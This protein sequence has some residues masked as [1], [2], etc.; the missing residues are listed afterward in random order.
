MG[1]DMFMFK[2][3][4]ENTVKKIVEIVEALKCENEKFIDLGFGRIKMTCMLDEDAERRMSHELD[5][6]QP[7]ATWRNANAINN[8][9]SKQFNIN[10]PIH[11]PLVLSRELLCKLYSCCKTVLE[12]CVDKDGN[13]N[14]DTKVCE[15]LL[16]CNENYKGYGYHN[17]YIQDI[18]DT[19]S[20]ISTIMLTTN[21]D[22]SNVLYV[23]DW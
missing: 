7:V 20:T 17:D 14:I 16:P 23:S 12:A 5:F 19:M 13:I 15:K 3:E 6:L 22:K 8:W 10:A 18:K 1:L 21:F 11:C 4:K 2:T 9:I